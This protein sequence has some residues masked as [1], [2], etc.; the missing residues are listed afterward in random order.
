[1]RLT[2]CFTSIQFFI[3]CL[4]IVN[5]TSAETFL[6]PDDQIVHKSIGLDITVSYNPN[7]AFLI[8]EQTVFVKTKA[9]GFTLKLSA[10]PDRYRCIGTTYVSYQPKGVYEILVYTDNIGRFGLENLLSEPSATP[11]KKANSVDKFSGLALAEPWGSVTPYFIPWKLWVLRT[12][13]PGQT[14]APVNP[15]GSIDPIY[16]ESTIPD[17]SPAQ[18]N[19]DL[20]YYYIPEKLAVDINN[21]EY[22][23]YKKVIA[24]TADGIKPFRIEVTLGINLSEP[25]FY[26]N[27]TNLSHKKYEGILYFDLV[28]N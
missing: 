10:D 21:G 24:S 2:S 1:M 13:G 3:L 18:D 26:H 7:P 19:P 28:G 25:N 23:S 12:A 9:D 14:T 5:I 6:S 15:D 27:A 16:W 17:S 4:L 8:V 11:Q 20:S 22:G